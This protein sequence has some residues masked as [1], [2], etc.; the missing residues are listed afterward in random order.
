MDC[1]VIPGEQRGQYFQNA[2][3][4]GAL[5]AHQAPVAEHPVR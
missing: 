1:A 2:F 5:Y 3:Q 4:V